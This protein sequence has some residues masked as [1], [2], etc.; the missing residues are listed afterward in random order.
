MG[1]PPMPVRFLL[2]LLL[3][4]ILVP[5][6][7][8]SAH[9][10]TPAEEI[11]W[12]EKRLSGKVLERSRAPQ[13]YALIEGISKDLNVSLN[14]PPHKG[15]KN[16]RLDGVCIIESE[17]SNASILKYDR[18][19]SEEPYAIAVTTSYLK[20]S[21]PQ[22]EEARA[23]SVSIELLRDSSYPTSSV[24]EVVTFQVLKQ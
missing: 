3:S 22:F 17:I 4:L 14:K 10:D 5:G 12:I 8:S 15:D 24:A 18:F 13:L 6:Y 21:D 16:K 1:A 2:F 19:Q 23:D 9:G 7:F 20:E 11:K